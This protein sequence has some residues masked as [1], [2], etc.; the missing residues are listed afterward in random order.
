MRNYNYRINAKH[1]EQSKRKELY[2]NRGYWP[3]MPHKG[4]DENGKEYYTEGFAGRYKK[5]LKVQANKAVRRAELNS[6][7]SGCHYKK[8]YE[9]LCQWY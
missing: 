8:M 5:F 1:K 7:N 9:L 2:S 4:I 3:S 6:V